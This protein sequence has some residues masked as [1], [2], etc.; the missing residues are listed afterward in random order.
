ML[1]QRWASVED[2]E[3][4][5]LGGH[6]VFVVTVLHSPSAGLM[7]AHRRR[8]LPNINPALGECVVLV[9]NVLTC[10][11]MFSLISIITHTYI[12]IVFIMTYTVYTRRRRTLV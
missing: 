10:I 11:T 5:I 4:A 8:N 2:A 3:P 6:F 9:G 1:Y 12:A 7:L